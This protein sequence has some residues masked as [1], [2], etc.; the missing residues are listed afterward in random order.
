VTGCEAIVAV[1][2][3]AGGVE[4]LIHLMASLPGDLPA[5]VL[6]TLHI[7][8]DTRSR[9]PQILSRAGRLPAEHARDDAMLEPGRV[10]VAPPDRHLLVVDGRV[11]L[12]AGP[13]INR[14]R[15]AID[16]MLGSIAREAGLRALAVV[17]SGS[18][19]DGAV[20]ATLLR[21]HGGRVLVQDPQDALF[22]SMPRAA[23]AAVPDALVAPSDVLGEAVVTT[24]AQMPARGGATTNHETGS[25]M[26]DTHDPG[27]LATDETRLTRLAC[28]DCGGGLAEVD[29]GDIS[30]FRCHVGHRYSP[31][32]LEAAQRDSAERK[33][34]AAAAALEEHAVLARHLAGRSSSA[35]EATGRYREVAE[36]A[37][38]TARLLADRLRSR[39]ADAV[40]PKQR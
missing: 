35:E 7:P 36:E 29:L 28:P 14:H 30:Y 1:G 26:P 31:Q 40:G 15:P 27:F 2:G 21:R 17:L 19:D 32:A 38:E 9:L 39:S 37:A 10:V 5:G 22:P 6:V 16:A 3:S 11:R 4:A 34:W 24:L 23:L 12:S 20:G 25:S 8:P 18:L 33:L 13:H